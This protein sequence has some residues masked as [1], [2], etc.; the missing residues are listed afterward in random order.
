MPTWCLDLERC[1]TS[2]AT[3]DWIFQAAIHGLDM[4][5][6]IAAL[7]DLIDPQETLC[8]GSMYGG[9]GKNLEPEKL[10]RMV[11]SAA[12]P[13][14]ETRMK[15]SEMKFTHAGSK[16]TDPDHLFKKQ[17]SRRRNDVHEGK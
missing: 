16:E 1:T 9:L 6:L 12:A 5:G 17:I 15:A 4:E 11:Q 8:S 14:A 2:A 13:Q 7:R 10:E 3:L